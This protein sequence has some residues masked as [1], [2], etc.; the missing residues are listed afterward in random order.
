[1]KKSLLTA[2]LI[3]ISMLT[4]CNAGNMAGEQDEGIYQRNGNT[5]NVNED[6]EELDNGINVLND[7][8]NNNNNNNGNNDNRNNNNRHNNN[9]NSK[10]FG[11]V[12]QQSSPVPGE[13]IS[14]KDMPT[15]DRE[16]TADAISR[17][18]LSNPGVK[19]SA[20]LVT[21]EEVL[22][23]YDT[24]ANTKKDRQ[25]TAEQVRRTAES[26]VPSWYHIYVTDDTALRRDIENI[27]SMDATRRN[28]HDTIDRT[29]KLMKEDSPQGQDDQ[30]GGEQKNE[31]GNI[32]GDMG[33]N[34]S[35]TK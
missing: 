3:G 7:N 15:L 33:N 23:A 2:G 20:V 12:R 13:T 16:K 6:R 9:N 34:R 21:D 25:Y 35:D 22:I 26:V 24:D 32:G 29:V 5:L 17:L 10:A 14:Q 30:N 11:Y 27:A 31:R 8:G 18:C 19:D 4:A 1:M 28:A